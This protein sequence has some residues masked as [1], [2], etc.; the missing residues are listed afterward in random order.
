[1]AIQYF[2]LAAIV[3]TTS[4]IAQTLS[5]SY[6]IKTAFP[7]Y[8]CRRCLDHF[9]NS[10]YCADQDSEQFGACCPLPDSA[11]ALDKITDPMCLHTDQ[12]GQTCSH[13][14][15]AEVIGTE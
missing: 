5:G 11:T 13:R 8:E 12:L 1:M 10:Y 3:L 9:S 2:L 7:T 15:Q 6:V 4:T 14:V